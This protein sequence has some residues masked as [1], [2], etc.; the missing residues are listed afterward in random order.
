MS[1]LLNLQA[2]IGFG[3]SNVNAIHC[4]VYV[5][6]T[7]LAEIA[8]YLIYFNQSR[9]EIGTEVGRRAVAQLSSYGERH[10]R[11]LNPACNSNKFDCR[12]EQQRRDR[13]EKR[14]GSLST[15][16]VSGRY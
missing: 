9:H 8:P 15:T 5:K 3:V 6:Q 1:E 16:L 7:R 10:N 13:T 14:G 11:L 4:D 12:P 2:G